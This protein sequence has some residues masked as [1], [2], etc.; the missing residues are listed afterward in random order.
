[1]CAAIAPGSVELFRD[2]W[3]Q[4]GAWNLVFLAGTVAGGFI[5]GRC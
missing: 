1:M 2:D 5:A 4:R 3:R